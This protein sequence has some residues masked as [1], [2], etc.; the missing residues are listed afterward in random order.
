MSVEEH[1]FEYQE[2]F[3]GDGA[4]AL[5]SCGRFE[6]DC[7]DLESA[8]EAWENHCDAVFYEATS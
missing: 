8:Q 1:I 3:L 2:S 5:C 6:K 4:M 7:V